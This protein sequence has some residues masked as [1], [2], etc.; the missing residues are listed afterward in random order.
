MHKYFD[1]LGEKKGQIDLSDQAL[2]QVNIHTLSSFLKKYPTKHW[3]YLIA[4][5]GSLK[6]TGYIQK[7]APYILTY[8][9]CLKTTSHNFHLQS[10]LNCF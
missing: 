2:N 9:I 3:A 10:L 5:W 4:M 6:S 8:W 1:Q 7:V